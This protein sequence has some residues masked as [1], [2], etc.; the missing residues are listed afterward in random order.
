[1]GRPVIAT[2]TTAPSYG[3]WI[4]RGATTLW[5]D[6]NGGSSRNHIMFGDISAWFYK[7]IAGI[8]AGAPGFKRIVIKPHVLG[9]L[10]FAR[11]TYDSAHGRIRSA[12]TKQ[13][14]AFVLSVVIPANTT[15]TVFVP[16]ADGA[17]VTEGNPH[18]ARAA[19]GV[20]LLRRE[21]GYT[22]YEVGAGSFRFKARYDGTKRRSAA[23][24]PK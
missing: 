14:G 19:E 2:Q 18:A 13:G 24:P 5:E 23:I 10:T 16:A 3:D 6:W 8:N 22:V 15:A 9:D 11:A 4:R 1:M 20:R 17:A 7:T 21:A 12:W